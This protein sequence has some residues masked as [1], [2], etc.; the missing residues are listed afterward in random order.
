MNNI[1]KV[2]PLFP[3][4]RDVWTHG[5]RCQTHWSIWYMESR[6]QNIHIMQIDS[7]RWGSRLDSFIFNWQRKWDGV[8]FYSKD[9]SDVLLLEQID[10]DHL[11]RRR[12]C[13]LYRSVSSHRREHMLSNV[14]SRNGKHLQ[15]QLFRSFGKVAGSGGK[16]GRHPHEPDYNPINGNSYS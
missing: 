2:L 4:P 12:N 7:I 11:V 5:V 1:V 15:I 10:F 8:D 3:P 9:V 16:I 13:F 6:D 14:I